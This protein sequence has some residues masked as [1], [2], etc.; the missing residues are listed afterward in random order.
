M[1]Q[2]NWLPP[3]VLLA[4]YGGDWEA[5]QENLYIFFKEDF[6][7][8]KPLFRGTKLSLKRHPLFQDKEA[9][10]WHITSE[11]IT[12]SERTPDLRRCERIRWLRSIIENADDPTIKLWENQ[13]KGETRI[14]LWL[15]EQEYIVI[16]AKRKDYILLWTAYLVTR[17]HQKQKL[18][19]EYEAYEKS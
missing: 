17:T 18:Q 5:Y 9:T 14:C 2:P 16:L 3:L 8:S 11:G 19:R 15:E 10:F 6:I 13:R 4:D 7:N 1:I 12:E